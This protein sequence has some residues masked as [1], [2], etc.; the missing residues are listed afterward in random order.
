MNKKY[1]EAIICACTQKHSAIFFI[2]F[3]KLLEYVPFKTLHLVVPDEDWQHFHDLY[4]NNRMLIL[5]KDS[6]FISSRLNEHIKN[7]LGRRKR[8]YGWYIQQLI[9]IKLSSNFEDMDNILIWDSDTIPLRPLNFIRN[10]GEFN[11]Y[12]GSEFHKPYFNTL[13]KILGIDKVSPHSFIAQCFPLKSI[14]AKD[15]I[16]NI[17]KKYWMEKIID[18]LDQSSDCAFSEY[19]SLGNF[20]LTKK[21]VNFIDFPWERNGVVHLY[22]F[23]S[24]RK[25]IIFLEK[26]YAFVAFEN[27]KLS[28]AKKLIYRLLKLFKR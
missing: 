1:F 8:M 26:N 12:Y 6:Q 27:I 9:K 11:Y 21:D 16:E 2:A 20:I 24:I 28:R 17:D 5:Y 19:E 22:K 10:D 4:K 3:E 18:N 15:F 14:L 25:A 7:K 23:R 13:K